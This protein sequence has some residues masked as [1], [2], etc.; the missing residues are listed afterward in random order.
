MPRTGVRSS[1]HIPARSPSTTTT[2]TRRIV[3]EHCFCAAHSVVRYCSASLCIPTVAEGVLGS[4]S[5]ILCHCVP[6]SRYVAPIKIAVEPNHTSCDLTAATSGYI[7]GSVFLLV[8]A[9]WN[10]SA[11]NRVAGASERKT[12]HCPL[13]PAAISP[14]HM[15]ACD[16]FECTVNCLLFIAI[17]R[18]IFNTRM[19]VVIALSP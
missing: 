6:Q 2:S 18:F 4:Y 14:V 7:E 10:T 9:C 8:F 13:L 5:K 11:L 1:R 17:S 19:C 3:S 15:I 12:I 16:C